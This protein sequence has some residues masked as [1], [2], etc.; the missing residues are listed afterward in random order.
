MREQAALLLG[1]RASGLALLAALL[2]EPAAL[3]QAIQPPPPAPVKPVAPAP[4]AAP[5]AAPKAT[6]GPE[7]V[8]LPVGRAEI[9]KLPRP[10][11]D[12][13]VAKSEVADVIVKTPTQVYVVGKTVGETNIF[14]IA[15]DGTITHNLLARVEMDLGPARAALQALLADESIEIKALNESIVLSGSVRSS[16]ASADASAVARRFVKE[17]AN[18]VNMLRILEDQQ[19]LLQVRVAEVQRNVLKNLGFQMDFNRVIGGDRFS[20]TSTVPVTLE[21]AATG[22]LVINDLGLGRGVFSA[23]ERQ[24]LVKTLAEPTLTAISGEPASFLAGGTVPIVTGVDQ[25]GNPVLTQREVGVGLSFT[26]VVLANDQ[27]SLRIATEVSRRDRTN[28]VTVR[29]GNNNVEIEG[30]SIRRAGSTVTLPTGGNLMIAGLLQ[31]DEFNDIDAT[32]GFKDL[33]VLGALFRSTRFQKAQSELVV[34]VTAYLVRPVEGR[35]KLALPTD[36][37]APASD[38]DIYLMGRLHAQYA[39]RKERPQIPMLRGPFG[40]IME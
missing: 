10:V 15:G 5:R 6:P 1:L 32:P 34:M 18:V 31:D 36:G 4:L 28:R 22:A 24:G 9:V 37:F 17:D 11:R 14:F 27:I 23:L 2:G 12:V 20:V 39:K 21:S 33:P 7:T 29:I 35:Q 25:N 40:Y 8:V 19:V 13:V 16:K 26:P 3:A 38:I 30:L